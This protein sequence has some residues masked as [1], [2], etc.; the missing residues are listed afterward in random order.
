MHGAR[1]YHMH[2][3]W[4][5]E[6][7]DLTREYHYWATHLTKSGHLAFQHMTGLKDMV[8]MERVDVEKGALVSL[9]GNT[10]IVQFISASQI[11]TYHYYTH[12]H[13]QARTHEHTIMPWV[14]KDA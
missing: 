14:L 9:G 4:G 6:V 10:M 13:T 7:G 8:H 3:R 5:G 1:R 11:D 12:T 2:V